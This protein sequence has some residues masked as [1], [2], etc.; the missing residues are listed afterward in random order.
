MEKRKTSITLDNSTLDLI[1][2]FILFIKEETGLRLSNRSWL[3]REM[4]TEYIYRRF[5]ER[6]RVSEGTNVTVSEGSKIEG[7]GQ[8]RGGEPKLVEEKN[9]EGGEKNVEKS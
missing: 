8:E 6:H 5:N 9:G 1:D 4:I 7:S 3:I 2:Q